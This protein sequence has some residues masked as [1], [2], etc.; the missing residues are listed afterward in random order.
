M[1]PEISLDNQRPAQYVFAK[2]VQ[3]TL[4]EINA[5]KARKAAEKAKLANAARATS[6][7]GG[8]NNRDLS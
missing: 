4:T 5:E 3:K 2:Q 1:A 8:A 7:D 6:H